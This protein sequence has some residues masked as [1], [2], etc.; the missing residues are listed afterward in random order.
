MNWILYSS[1]AVLL[2]G[3]EMLYMR[4]A[5]RFNIVDRP[6]HRSS[7][8]HL[9]VRGGGVIFWL[10]AL[11]AFVVGGFANPVFFAGLTLVAF[12]S[13]LDDVN[14]VSSRVRFGIQLL[15]IGLLLYQ[16]GL[17]TDLG[18]WLAL[19]VVLACGVLN[20]C[21]FLDGINGMTA[22]YGIVTVATLLLINRFWLP[23]ADP[24]LPGFTLLS[25]AVFTVFNARRTAWCFAGDVG[26]VSMA[27]I[28]LFLLITLMH[29]SGLLTYGLLLTVYGIDSVLTILYRL[30]QGENIFQ[31]HRQHLYQLLVHRL[32]W[33]HLRVA[34]LYAL[35]QALINGLVI[36]LVRQD[37]VTQLWGGFFLLA[38]LTLGYCLLKNRLLK[39]TASEEMVAR[40]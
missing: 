6:N 14:S 37:G 30:W 7:H 12:I 23:F 25:L 31:A 20:A 9:T 21:N 24:V 11:V 32:K 8:R 15:G 4:L 28:V 2:L 17:G 16:T 5:T 10:A 22:F 40:A 35:V 19:V 26:S 1:L 39:P 36:A 34:G 33:P 27:F 18:W 38:V 13:F 29:K 3:A